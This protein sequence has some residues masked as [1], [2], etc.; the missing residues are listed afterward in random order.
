MHS[1]VH[2]DIFVYLLLLPYFTFIRKLVYSA[3]FKS[4]GCNH[5]ISQLR[6]VGNFGLLKFFQG[7][8][9]LLLWY[10]SLP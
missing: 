7:S 4:V 8:V 3:K 2:N 6:H 5:E 10:T 1:N 9:L